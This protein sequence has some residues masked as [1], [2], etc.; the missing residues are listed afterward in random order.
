MLIKRCEIIHA[1]TSVVFT[2]MRFHRGC[3]R[4]SLI[5]EGVFLKSEGGTED[6][7]WNIYTRV[8]DGE[9]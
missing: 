3:M 7:D 5:A 2:K 4:R 9:L 8:G 1:P 6:R